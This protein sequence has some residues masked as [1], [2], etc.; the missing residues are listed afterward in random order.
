MR[1]LISLA[2]A[3]TLFALPVRA[4]T[5][6]F[7][8]SSTFGGG[9]VTLTG[10]LTRPGGPAP[11]PAV[12]LMHGCGGLQ[13]GVQAGLKAHAAA[14]AEAGFAALILDSF[15]PRGNGGGHVCE[16]LDRLANARRYRL[17]DAEDAR[18]FLSGLEGIDADN[19][20]L[21][22]QS[23]GGS[24]AIRAA[25]RGARRFRA[26]AA[27]YPWCGVFNRLGAKA[28]IDTPLIVFGGAKDDWVPPEACTTIKAEGE[29]YQVHV[30]PEAPHSFDLPVPQQRY[31]GK[32]VGEDAEATADSRARMIGFFQS[33]LAAR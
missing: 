33:H 15:G 6:S 31:L 3:A 24:V 32:L 29:A 11:A 9:P 17:R 25:Q 16:S 5:V 21:M 23:N 20:F 26:I 10:A 18:A 14:L 7:A 2:L 4:E 8:A 19:I 22:G 12:I 1:R 27:Y 28:V 13:P 30:Y